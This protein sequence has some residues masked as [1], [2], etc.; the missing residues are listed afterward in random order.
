MNILFIILMASGIVALYIGT[1]FYL[2]ITMRKVLS[3]QSSNAE[4][5]TLF[6]TLIASGAV[7]LILL[8]TML[9]DVYKA[10]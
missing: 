10:G 9:Q 3:S 1:L 2:P 6:I 4:K 5:T 8:T 7:A